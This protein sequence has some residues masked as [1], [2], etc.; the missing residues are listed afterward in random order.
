[1]RA[2]ILNDG[3]TFSGVAG[4]KLVAVADGIAGDDVDAAIKA[5]AYTL[6]HEFRGDEAEPVGG[7]CGFSGPE[8]E[9]LRALL[10]E[11]ASLSER[12]ATL[13][14]ATTAEQ[15]VYGRDAELLRRQARLL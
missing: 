11:Y 8:R 7:S 6:L 9:R 4:C 1:M 15:V 2:V 10:A 13:A 12:I 3:E 5:G 14:H